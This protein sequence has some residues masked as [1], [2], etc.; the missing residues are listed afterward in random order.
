MS[1][2][3]SLINPEGTYA[4]EGREL[5]RL[6]AMERTEPIEPSTITTIPPKRTNGDRIRAMSNEELSA[7]FAS[8]C[9]FCTNNGIR[10]TLCREMV[11]ANCADIILAWL[12]SEVD[13]AG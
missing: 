11:D 3:T 2:E 8:N 10:N 7:M 12:N 13:D 9:S 6:R 1:D 5:I 4:I